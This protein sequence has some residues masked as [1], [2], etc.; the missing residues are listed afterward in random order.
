MGSLVGIMIVTLGKTNLDFY[1]NIIVALFYPIAIIIGKNYS[2]NTVISSMILVQIILFIFS[3]YIFYKQ[4]INLFFYEYFILHLKPLLIVF[5]LLFSTIYLER[6]SIYKLFVWVLFVVL[7][8]YNFL[9]SDD[10]F[11]NFIK[12]NF[13]IKN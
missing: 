13:L 10:K 1:W 6:F 3:W 2:L 7:L 8:A 4:T 9:Q 12:N 5:P 11:K